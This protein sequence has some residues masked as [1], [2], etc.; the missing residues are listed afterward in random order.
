M[1]RKKKLLTKTMLAFLLSVTLSACGGQ[2]ATEP[3]DTTQHASETQQPSEEVQPSESSISSESVDA[4][5]REDDKN[6]SVEEEPAEYEYIVK[7]FEIPDNEGI[8]MVENMKIGWNLG[9]S[10][11]AIDCGLADE[12]KYESAWCGVNA[13]PEL[14]A[15]LKKA[16]FNTVRIPVSWHNHL[17]DESA[18]TISQPWLDRVKEVVGYALAEDM[19]VIVN[20]HHDNSKQFIYPSNEYKD[21][22]ANYVKRI[23]TQL[24]EAFRD[25]DE[26]V[27]FAG[28]N[29]PRLVGHNNEWWIDANNQDC[30]D[31][32]AIINELNQLFVDTVRASGGNN[33]SRYLI[34]PGYD[35]SPDGATNKGFVFPTDPVDNDHHIILSIHAYTPYNF[36]LESP[37]VDDWSS[38]NARDLSNMVGF[39]NKIY[40]TYI[41]NGTPVIIDE[42]GAMEKNGNLSARTDFAGCFIANAKARGMSCI[43]WDNNVTKG[44]GERFGIINRKTLEWQFPEIVENMMKQFE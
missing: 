16:G 38:K 34:C 10:F 22:S 21:Q 24:A 15:E 1:T 7:E 3:T 31:A 23:W 36:A 39:M 2:Q 26:K 5:S 35:A 4:E 8:R 11:D 28:M 18:Y 44:S 40:S 6:S 29:E 43:W 12:M 13:T 17:T 37:G 19:Y 25:Y 27:L 14:F 42:F 33:A 9:N 41:Q 20:I 32:I 30:K